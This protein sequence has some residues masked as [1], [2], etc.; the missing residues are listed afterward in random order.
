MT[1]QNANKLGRKLW[2][3]ERV[4]FECR[5]KF[6]EE[7]MLIEKLRKEKFGKKMYNNYL[8]DYDGRTVEENKR[9]VQYQLYFMK[10]QRGLV[11][12]GI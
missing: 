12:E 6:G 1:S 3:K 4:M 5:R 2:R 8:I 11:R 10:M 7:E 9:L